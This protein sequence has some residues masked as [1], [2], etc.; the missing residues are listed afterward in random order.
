MARTYKVKIAVKKPENTCWDCKIRAFNWK[1]DYE[2]L[3]HLYLSSGMSPKS[4]HFNAM[5]VANNKYVNNRR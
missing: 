4:S 1:Q 3:K 2:A 5:I